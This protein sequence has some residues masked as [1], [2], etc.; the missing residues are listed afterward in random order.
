MNSGQECTTF[1]GSL[2]L[3]FESN[4]NHIEMADEF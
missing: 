2:G 1:V 4:L 3:I